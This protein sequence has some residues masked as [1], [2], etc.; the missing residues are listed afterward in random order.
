MTA[1]PWLSDVEA[2]VRRIGAQL[3]VASD[4]GVYGEHCIVCEA[5]WALP[6]DQ[7]SCAHAAICEDCYPNGCAVCEAEVESGIRRREQA[8]DRILSAA[9]ELRTGADD[10]S[11][12]DLREI[13]WITRKDVMRHV[14]FAIEA[15]QRVLDTIHATEKRGTP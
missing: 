2:S 14:G 7:A 5:R 6:A 8:A 10:L 11:E 1:D 12:A 4:P 15:L 13:S 3:G 9:L